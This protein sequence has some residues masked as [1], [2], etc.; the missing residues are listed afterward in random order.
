M[1]QTHHSSEGGV[2]KFLS[3]YYHLLRQ[4][5]KAYTFYTLHKKT[6]GYSLAFLSILLG[7]LYFYVTSTTLI[8]LEEKGQTIHNGHIAYSNP[9]TLHHFK[10]KLHSKITQTIQL[11]IVADDRVQDLRVNGEKTPPIVK[12]QDGRTS[13]KTAKYGDIFE[14]TVTKGENLLVIRSLNKGH[15]YTITVAQHRSLQDYIVAYILIILPLIIISFQLFLLLSSQKSIVYRTVLQIPPLAYL[16]AFAIILRI[17][18]FHDMGHG[19]FQHDYYGH[20]EYIKF[21]AEYFMVPMADKGWEFP[22]QPLYYMVAGTIFKAGQLLNYQE[23]QILYFIS[24]VTSVLS[25]IALIFAYRLVRLLAPNNHFVHFLTIGFLAFTPSIQYMSARISNDPFSFSLATI[26]LFYIV[27]SYK[28]SFNQYL[29][30]ALLF[31]SLALLT[32]VST[33][34]VW[35]FFFVALITC[36]FKAPQKYQRPLFHYAWLGILLLSYTIYKS[37]SFATGDLVMVNSGIWPG[38]DLRPMDANYLLS[39]NFSDLFNQAHAYWNDDETQQ[40]KRSFWTYQ[41]GTM[42]FGE[43]HYGNP[44]NAHYH[45]IITMQMIIVLALLFPIGIIAALFRK[46]SLIENGLLIMA[47]ANVLLLIKFMFEFPSSA[48]TDFRYYAPCF[49][50]MAYLMAI[51]LDSLAA[52]HHVIKKFIYWAAGLL[53]GF[54]ALFLWTLTL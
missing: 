2:I 30:P 37:Y 25:C 51:G 54:Q 4:A 1:N 35:L 31:S 29:F 16:I 19:Q 11:N 44:K 17:F 38:Q 7:S 27:A 52:L 8:H 22:Q 10:A 15:N 26:A 41:Y 47:I 33:I 42:L 9:N 3:A 28:K 50:A 18:Y 34:S 46:K 32:K 5:S 24:G 43:F 21:F 36:Y 39:F 53:F 12:Y 20:I 49:F 40:I 14:A 6:L 48:N 45:M 13:H 23:G